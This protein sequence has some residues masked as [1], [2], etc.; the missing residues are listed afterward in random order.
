MCEGLPCS[1]GLPTF[2]DQQCQSHDRQASKKKNQMWSAVID[3]GKT[4]NTP[5]V[6]YLSM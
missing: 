1:K 4:K 3:D 2:R 5:L 6:E